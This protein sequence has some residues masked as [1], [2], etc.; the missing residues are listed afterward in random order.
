MYSKGQ[1]KRSWRSPKMNS[2]FKATLSGNSA[3]SFLIAKSSLK[4]SSVEGTSEALENSR[5]LLQLETG[6][7]GVA[8]V[9]QFSLLH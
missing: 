3:L 6:E 1:A 8:S 2:P 4:T 7:D 9:G 5:T